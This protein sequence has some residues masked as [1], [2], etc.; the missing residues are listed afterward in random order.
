MNIPVDDLGLGW[1]NYPVTER[2]PSTVK[3]GGVATWWRPG[4]CGKMASRRRTS[5]AVTTYKLFCIRRLKTCLHPNGG[6]HDRRQLMAVSSPLHQFSLA[7]LSSDNPF[8]GLHRGIQLGT[9][10]L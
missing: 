9:F 3:L 6:V 10:C 1:M 2:S 5:A 7:V 8:H 4:F